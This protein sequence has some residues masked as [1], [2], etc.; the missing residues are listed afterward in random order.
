MSNSDSISKK[1][2]SVSITESSSEESSSAI[3]KE[4]END[5]T[6]TNHKTPKTSKLNEVESSNARNTRFKETHDSSDVSIQSNM[7]NI[8]V[9]L[10]NKVDETLE[11]IE[12]P[13]PPKK[14]PS[15]YDSIRH[16]VVT[17]DG[18]EDALIK[19]VG[20]KSLFSKQLPKMPKEYIARLVFDRRHKTLAV[21]SNDPRHKGG[22]EE[23]IGGICYRPYHD[24]RF[25]EIAFC[26]VSGIQQVKGYGTKLMN[27]LKQHC[28]KE[29]EYA[30]IEPMYHYRSY[31][32]IV[33]VY[34]LSF[35]NCI[36]VIF[37]TGIEYFITYADNFAIGYFKKQGFTKSISMPKGRYHGLIKDYNSSTPMECYIHPSI[38]YHRIPEML[39]AQRNF[40]LS[41]IKLVSKS[42]KIIYPPLPKD[43]K[44]NL[45]GVSR[46]NE[47]AAR[48]LAI[49]G[50][51]EAGWT[52]ADLQGINNGSKDADRHRH[53]IKS[54]LLNIIKK[55]ED[56]QFCW[57]FR[58]PVDTEEV[59]DYLEIIKDPIDLSTIDKRIRKGNW[60]QSKQMLHADL[61]RM[62]NNCKLYNDASSPYYE[63]AV[64][65]EEY[66]GTLFS[67]VQGS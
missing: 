28:V 8:P 48:A 42:D 55:L 21:L 44:P 19:L 57:P 23:I 31:V 47:T 9:N 4:L 66:L 34:L 64:Q 12:P 40:L 11:T 53:N 20:L 59:K 56:Q 10:G 39:K 13:P 36:H 25:A 27:M 52:M 24:M 63:C 41:R 43:F 50:V 65:V 5:N 54:E 7:K 17:N 15:A 30:T 45:E 22:D 2:K 1:R 33:Y 26:A 37:I 46:A 61:M 29:R 18:T 3:N 35:T 49:P 51:S 58:E 60:Y 67:D 14:G 16:I 32:C 6:S 38:D 62:V